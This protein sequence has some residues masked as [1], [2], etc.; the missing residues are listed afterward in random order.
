MLPEKFRL[1][2]NQGRRLAGADK[3]ELYT[4]LFKLVYRFGPAADPP[5]LGF[6]VSGKLGGS[7]KRNLIKR[8][9]S[10]AVSHRLE[11][12]PNGAEFIII[13]SKSAAEADYEEIC[14]CLDK[15]LPKIYR[16]R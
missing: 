12:F 16:G 7:A 14:A 13:A 11:K 3:K 9:F 1:K 8:R 10:E 6:I 15:V 2:I 4:P 5:K